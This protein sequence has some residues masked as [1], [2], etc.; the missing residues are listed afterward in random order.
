M[1]NVQIK[2]TCGCGYS[3][4]SQD[5]AVEHSDHQKHT[6]PVL[7]YIIPENGREEKKV[8]LIVEEDKEGR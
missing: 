1:A 5:E 8:T 4:H 3:T 2:F 7:G 6:I